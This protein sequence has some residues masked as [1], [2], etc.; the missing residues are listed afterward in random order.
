MEMNL[1]MNRNT[2]NSD[3]AVTSA[4]EQTEKEIIITQSPHTE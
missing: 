1:A 4:T 2:C 3:S